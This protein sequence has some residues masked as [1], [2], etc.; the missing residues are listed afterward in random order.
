MSDISNLNSTIVPKSDQLNADELVGG[1]RTIRI[2]DVRVIDSTEQPVSIFFEGDEG[3]PFKPSKTVRKI[4]IKGWGEDGRK[5]V[6][7]YM[8][9]YNEPTVKWAGVE[10]GGIRVSHMS[11]IEGTMRV[12]VNATKGKKGEHFVRP[13]EVPQESPSATLEDVLSA[14]HNASN[15]QTMEYAKNMAMQL[16]NEEDVKVAQDAYRNRVSELKNNSGKD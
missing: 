12:S 4:L 8:T 15:K 7:R 5:W 1:A 3:R 16:V 14:I 6:G 13:L 9:I 10:V 11:N 2:T